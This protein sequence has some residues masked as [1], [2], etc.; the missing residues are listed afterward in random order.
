MMRGGFKNYFPA[1]CF[2]KKEHS[3]TTSPYGYSS[4]KARRRKIGEG[5]KNPR[6]M[7]I[8]G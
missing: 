8:R 6:T 2:V 7:M 3:K 5:Q 1:Q 4:L